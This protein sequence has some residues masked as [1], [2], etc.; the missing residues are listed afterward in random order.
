MSDGIVYFTVQEVCWSC[1]GDADRCFICGGTGLREHIVEV[2]A[3][4][5]EAEIVL[6]RLYGFIEDYES[7]YDL[8]DDEDDEF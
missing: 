4:T 7:M 6:R 1:G 5:K 8:D 3:T 2:L